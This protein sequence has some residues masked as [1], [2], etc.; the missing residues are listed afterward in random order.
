MGWRTELVGSYRNFCTRLFRQHQWTLLF[1]VTMLTIRVVAKCREIW[2]EFNDQCKNWISY[3]L[4]TGAPHV[5]KISQLARSS[6]RSLWDRNPN[7]SQ[8]YNLTTSRPGEAF[9]PLRP[10]VCIR[11][12]WERLHGS[13]KQWIISSVPQSS[14]SLVVWPQQW[15]ITH[16]MRNY[17][18][19]ERK[20][21]NCILKYKPHCHCNRI[22]FTCIYNYVAS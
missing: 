22:H 9:Q 10:C 14:L 21:L 3:K 5:E 15:E 4:V 7:T 13:R 2:Y 16:A 1:C 8:R 18:S 12:C 19:P 20:S 6:V 11:M 17:P